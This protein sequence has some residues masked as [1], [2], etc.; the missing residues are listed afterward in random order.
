MEISVVM[1]VYQMGRFLPQAMESL[2][3][4]TFRDFEILLID[5]GS[6]DG[7]GEECDRQAA[8]REQVRVFHKENGGLSSARNTGIDHAR[9]KYIIFPDPDDWVEP[10]YL[11]R[12]YELSH[13]KDSVDL[14]ICGHYETMG[15]HERRW[16]PSEDRRE[17]TAD[18]ALNLLMRQDC[19][20]GYAWNKLYR[21]DLI[22]EHK[23]RFEEDLHMAEDLLFAVRYLCLVRLVLYD[24]EPLY[25]YCRDHGGVTRAGAIGAKHLSGLKT[26]ERIADLVRVTHPEVGRE[27]Y[28]SLC[29]MSLLYMGV[30]LR[31]EQKQPETLKLLQ[32]EFRQYRR[33]FYASGRFTLRHKCAAAFAAVS[34]RFYC[35]LTR[36]FGHM[37][38]SQL[39]ARGRLTGER[40]NSG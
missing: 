39:R 26:Y 19:Y 29:E 13:E 28:A 4:Q 22:R 12:L 10:D 24:P 18:E 25:H 27:A 31:G 36:I 34:P 21:V 8:G 9:G 5:D 7:S 15:E 20:C 23:L 35:F 6:T 40:D 17:L 38:K 11:N 2:M 37:R 33:Y 14:A 30:Y 1:P 16:D 3:A 32:K